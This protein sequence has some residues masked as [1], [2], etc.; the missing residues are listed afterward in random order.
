M[1][2]ENSGGVNHF[3]I[4]EAVEEVCILVDNFAKTLPQQAF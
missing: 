3:T 2:T 1:H 4:T